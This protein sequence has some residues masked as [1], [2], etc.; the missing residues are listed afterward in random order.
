MAAARTEAAA[1]RRAGTLAIA[2]AL[3]LAAT[4]ASPAAFADELR[5]FEASYEWIWN[6]MTVAVTTLKLERSGATW[7][8]SSRSKPRGIGRLMPQ[9]P[10][11]VSVLEVTD[12]GVRPRSYRGDDGTGSTKRTVNVTYDW[13]RQRVTGVYEDT[14]L[15]LP[16]SPAV[17]DES[18]VQIAMMVELLRGR[19]PERFELL[20]KNQ[21]R[22]YRYK[23]EGESTIHTPLGDVAT[24]IYSSQ[25]ANSPR[26]NRYWCA[27][28]RGYIPVRVEQKRGDEVQWTMEILTLKRE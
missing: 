2:L 23:R 12:A 20:D 5:P 11:T 22:E 15:D 7:T 27:P 26:V 10:K 8:Y 17:Q 28:E 13:S 24:V 21:V 4:A 1:G 9:R 6:G 14:P 18:S 3:L 19:T 16:L 25:R